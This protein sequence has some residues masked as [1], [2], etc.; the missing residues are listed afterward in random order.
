VIDTAIISDASKS[1]VVV[2]DIAVA[3]VEK[4]KRIKVHNEDS[5][6]PNVGQSFDTLVLPSDE[7]AR[8]DLEPLRAQVRAR[9]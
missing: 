8:R 9:P 6:T 4:M 2:T 3:R 7:V 1:T 5:L